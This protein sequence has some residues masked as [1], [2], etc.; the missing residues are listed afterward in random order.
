MKNI[1]C[2]K[3]K[4]MFLPIH[5]PFWSKPLNVS[6]LAAELPLL[7]SWTPQIQK[8]RVGRGRFLLQTGEISADAEIWCGEYHI[9]L[10]RGKKEA[11]IFHQLLLFFLCLKDKPEPGSSAELWMAQACLGQ[12]QP[13]AGL[14]VANACLNAVKLLLVWETPVGLRLWSAKTPSAL[15]AVK[16]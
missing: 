7:Q 12:Q 16:Y 4:Q 10:D 2:R 5:N 6:L 8:P 15:T 14:R 11:A 9:I 3:T 1:I 13:P